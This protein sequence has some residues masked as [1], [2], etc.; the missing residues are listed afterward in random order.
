MCNVY[1]DRRTCFIV[2]IMFVFSS[3][4]CA[5]EKQNSVAFAYSVL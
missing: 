2:F 4:T 3:T 1:F 5:F